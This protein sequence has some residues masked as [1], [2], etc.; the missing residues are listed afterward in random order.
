MYEVRLPTRRVQRELQ[1]LQEPD[2]G[3][4]IVRLRALAEDAR[5]PDCEKVLDAIYRV[6]A[7]DLRII[8]L[9]DDRE[10][11]IEIGTIRRRRERTYRGIEDLF[12]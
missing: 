9:I 5:P 1:S 2:Y 7:G 4:V 12:R 8:Y 11:R 3:R 6:R 10:K